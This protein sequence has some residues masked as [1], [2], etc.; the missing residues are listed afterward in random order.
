MRDNVRGQPIGFFDSGVG[1]LT[2]LALA[3]KLLPGE[4][5]IYFGDTANAPY[6]SKSVDEV[7]QLSLNAA[8]LLHDRGC[9]AMVVACNTATSAAVSL[10]RETLPFPV[11]GMEPAVKPALER[12]GKVLV[13]ATPLT[14]REE[15]FRSLCERCGADDEHVVVVP[16]PG[17]VEMVERGETEGSEVERTLRQLFAGVDLEG[18]TGVVLGCTHYLFLRKTLSRL[19][20][21][22]VEFING[23]LGTVRQLTRILAKEGLLNGDSPCGN[24]IEFLSSG[25]CDSVELYKALFQIALAETEGME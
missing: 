21:D 7:R 12:G 4:S 10:L 23:N 16:C 25:G 17:L 18:I 5:F 19:L 6:G 13:M 22:N 14:L 3:V 2:V 8:K 11:I 9:K 20:P 15:K 1:G 24:P